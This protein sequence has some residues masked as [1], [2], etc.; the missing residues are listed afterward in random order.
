MS[1]LQEYLR[2]GG[3]STITK[4]LGVR[5]RQHPRYPN[6]YLFN[7]SQVG[8][9]KAHPVVV[10]CR[11]SILDKDSNWA[12]VCRPFDRFFNYGEGCAAEIDWSTA[13]VLTKEDGTFVAL[14]W[15]A[16]EWHVST[17]GVPDASGPVGS[18]GHTF[19]DLFWATLRGRGPQHDD[20]HC[21][22][23][24]ELCA[25]E[26]RVVVPYPEA[27]VKLIAVRSN[28]WGWEHTL[29]D[30]TDDFPCVEVHQLDTLDGILETFESLP[31]L[32]NEGYVVVDKYFNRI[33]VK[34]PGYVA[35][36]HLRGSGGDKQVLRLLLDGE[37]TEFL[38]YFPEHRPDFERIQDLLDACIR[39]LEAFWGRAKG[40]PTRKDF[41]LQVKAAGVQ[42]PGPLFK[43]WE[44]PDLDLEAEVRGLKVPY[45][46]RVLGLKD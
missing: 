42:P 41:A 43:K 20:R 46:L 7:Y 23:M 24:W 40:A 17:R 19:A 28:R 36:H 11:G 10:E 32:H 1:A 4:D 30:C 18:S 6:L 37:D 39:D 25:R 31:A 3:L 2:N 26:N 12:F 34:H 9:P 45:L 38:T 15:Y 21:T 27:Q 14:W 16:G 44:D 8:S 13:T 22:W 35:L 33:K 5:V 29:A